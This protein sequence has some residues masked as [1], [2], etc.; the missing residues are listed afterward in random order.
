MEVKTIYSQPRHNRVDCADHL[1]IG[2]VTRDT[3]NHASGERAN[4]KSELAPR[5]KRLVIDFVV[6]ESAGCQNSLP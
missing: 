3:I 2:E 4:M 1:R 6:F 5:Q